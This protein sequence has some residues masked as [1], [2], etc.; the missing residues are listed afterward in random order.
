M[1]SRLEKNLKEPRRYPDHESPIALAGGPG[2]PE[3]TISAKG[4]VVPWSLEPPGSTDL[5]LTLPPLSTD[6]LHGPS[7]HVSPW[8]PTLPSQLGD[9]EK[10]VLTWI[11]GKNFREERR[12]PRNDEDH[13]GQGPTCIVTETRSF[14]AKPPTEHLGTFTPWKVTDKEYIGKVPY[15]ACEYNEIF[16]EGN[17]DNPVLPTPSCF[18]IYR[19]TLERSFSGLL[20]YLG[21]YMIHRS[22]SCG[23]VFQTEKTEP[24]WYT[25]DI[26]AFIYVRT[27]I[28]NEP[29]YEY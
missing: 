21:F 23:H 15:G 12:K 24:Q 6:Q 26:P 2:K 28:V 3:V 16:L 29:V 19:I 17:P 14:Q 5:E 8:E 27:Q 1:Q 10:Q 22:C 11:R 20:R 4:T 9:F 25:E 13:G 18:K 7:F